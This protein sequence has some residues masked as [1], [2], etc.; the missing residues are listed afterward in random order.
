MSTP[1]ERSQDLDNQM[2]KANRKRD[3]EEQQLREKEFKDRDQDENE[4]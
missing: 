2:L 1:L 3:S 4:E